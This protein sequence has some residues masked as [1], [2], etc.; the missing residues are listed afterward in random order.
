MTR[1]ILV[2]AFFILTATQAWSEAIL[3]ADPYP[4]DSGISEFGV[5][6]DGGTT[7]YIP[8]TLHS[9]GAAI[10]YRGGVLEDDGRHEFR[11]WAIALDGRGSEIV[12]F[13]LYGRLSSPFAIQWR[14]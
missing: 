11:I 6:V 3:V 2:L 5:T 4:I 1:L 9:S 10:V 8:Y 14:P 7:E 12:P 13:T